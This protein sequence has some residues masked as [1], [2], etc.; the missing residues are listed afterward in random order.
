MPKTW[1]AEPFSDPSYIFQMPQ[2][3]IAKALSKANDNLVV[4]LDQ[5]S[6]RVLSSPIKKYA[7]DHHLNIDVIDG[8]CGNSAGMLRRKMIDIGGF[9]CP[10]GTADRLPGLQFHTTGITGVALLVHPDNPINNITL[11]QA[12]K[13]FRGNI[14]RWSELKNADGRSEVELP[15]QIITRLHCKTRPGHWRLLL[16]KEELFSLNMLEVGV[17]SDMIS[18]VASN[19]LAIG[20]AAWWF[21]IN[22][23]KDK[24][25]VK[26]LKIDGYAPNDLKALAAGNYP[27]YKAFYLTTWKGEK[28]ENPHAK[29]LVEFMKRAIEERGRNYGIV[30]V[31]SLVQAGWKFKG[32]ELIGERR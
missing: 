5:Q 6:Y 10:P 8:M 3:W 13:I 1:G 31:S 28:V 4:A 29:K 26:A 17:P 30:P 27:I 25:K 2:D 16:K 19:P 15:I 32:D 23:Y 20:H 12:R 21:A 14:Y 7:R 24:G 11:E 18:Q 9:C 22:Y